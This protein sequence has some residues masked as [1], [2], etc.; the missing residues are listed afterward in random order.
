M[1]IDL[2]LRKKP[3]LMMYSL[4]FLIIAVR[5]SCEVLTWFMSFCL[6]VF[7]KHC[8]PYSEISDVCVGRR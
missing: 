4:F 3:S 5:H 1:H 8:A 2:A 7:C 6:F